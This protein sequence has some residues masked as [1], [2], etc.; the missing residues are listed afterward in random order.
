MS[1]LL[2]QR[3]FGHFGV[4]LI[5]VFLQLELVRLE[6]ILLKVV[7]KDEVP[8]D[9]L[10]PVATVFSKP[11]DVVTLADPCAEEVLHSRLHGI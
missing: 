4:L 3:R 2:Q 6:W 1:G 7:A 5:V 11:V 8:A 9:K 10:I